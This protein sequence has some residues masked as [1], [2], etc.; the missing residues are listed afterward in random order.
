MP[1]VIRMDG[2][3]V[4]VVDELKEPVYP[5]SRQGGDEDESGHR[6]YR[7]RSRRTS[8]RIRSMVL[9]SFSTGIPL[10]HHDDAGLPRLMGQARHL[11]V[12]LRDAL[13]GVDED[14]A[15]IGPLN[16]HGGPEDGKFLDSRSSTLDFFRIPAVSMNR[17]LP[18]SF[19][20]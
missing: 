1:V 15:H 9:S 10:V 20:K 13:V 12:L 19:S 8:A 16:G 14:Q 11:G 2:L 6:S 17:Y 5:L 18:F 4:D 7:R 3:V